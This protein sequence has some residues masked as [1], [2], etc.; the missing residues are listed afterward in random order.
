MATGEFHDTLL[1]PSGR[2]IVG[3]ELG[4]LLPLGLRGEDEE[5]EMRVLAH[6]HLLNCLLECRAPPCWEC[7]SGGLFREHFQVPAHFY[8][9]S[10]V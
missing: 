9:I 4:S 8:L 7:P 1:I 5:L 2:S 3:W 6:E 10:C